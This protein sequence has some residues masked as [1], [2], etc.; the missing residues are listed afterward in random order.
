MQA[1]EQHVGDQHMSVVKTAIIGVGGGG[2]AHIR[3][4]RNIE[5]CEVKKVFDIKDASLERV[6]RQYGTP[7]TTDLREILDDREITAVSVCV[8]DMFHAEYCVRALEAGKHVI[9][10]K[11]LA[12]SWENCAKIINAVQATGM[13]FAVQHQMRFLKWSKLAKRLVDDGELGRLYAIEGDYVHDMTTRASLYDDWRM[14]KE[15][16]QNIVT[17]G[18]SHM[19]D[20]MR[21]LAGEVEEVFAYANHIAFPAYPV[22]DCAMILLRFRSGVI[23]RHL[24]ALGCKRPGEFPLVVMGTKGTL[25]SNKLFLEDMRTADYM[26]LP[27]YY[28][29]HERACTDSIAD[30]IDKVKNGGKPLVDVFESSKAVKICLAAIESYRTGKPVRAD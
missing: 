16:A 5:G 26:E 28:Y 6:K 29:D 11:P 20:L 15:T 1:R 17:G 24:V 14:K 21:Y 2:A 13:I 9:C 30:F 22:E 3:Y 19:M 12:D 25:K 10:E 8:P 27:G 23:G 7:G 18:S 4:M